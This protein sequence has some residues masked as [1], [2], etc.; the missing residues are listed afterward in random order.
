MNYL[1]L[2]E[3]SIINLSQR[4]T[5]IVTIFLILSS[6]RSHKLTGEINRQC[7]ILT[8]TNFDN[9]H[10]RLRM[11]RYRRRMSVDQS[12]LTLTQIYHQQHN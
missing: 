7:Q 12:R 1:M 5:L 3:G 4:S 11:P 10:S 8:D 9:G 2:I 6:L